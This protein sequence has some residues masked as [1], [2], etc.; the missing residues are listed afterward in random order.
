M[1]NYKHRGSRDALASELVELL[2]AAAD[3]SES[4]VQEQLKP[5]GLSVAQGRLFGL[6]ADLSIRGQ[7]PLQKDLEEGMGRV[8]STI[9]SLVQGL[10]KQGLLARVASNQDGRAK[11]IHI[12]ARGWE[13]Y[14]E[15]GRRLPR[16]H[17][18]LV[19]PWDDRQLS[20]AVDLLR[21]LVGTSG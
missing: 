15:L 2:R 21:S 3:R 11:E 7:A 5:H 9:T 17:R 4:L 18:D 6:V 1:S 20:T 16:W 10:E 12:T 19:A 13:V 8:T 14:K